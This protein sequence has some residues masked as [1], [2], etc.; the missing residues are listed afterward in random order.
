MLIP[1]S[2]KPLPLSLNPFSAVL[3]QV[4]LNGNL[5]IRASGKRYCRS[6]A[7]AMKTRKKLNLA[8]ALSDGKGPINL[9]GHLTSGRQRHSTGRSARADGGRNEVNHLAGGGSLKHERPASGK[10][11]GC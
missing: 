3:A 10:V 6:C 9:K 11:L 1:W 2:H 5:V 7:K 8:S 4:P